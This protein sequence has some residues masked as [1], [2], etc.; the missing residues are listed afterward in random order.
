MQDTILLAWATTLLSA[1]RDY[2]ITREMRESMGF[3]ENDYSLELR[4]Y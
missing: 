4:G 1:E 3:A 2:E